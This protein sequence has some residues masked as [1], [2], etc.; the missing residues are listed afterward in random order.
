MVTSVFECECIIF[1]FIIYNYKM[2][3][4]N[5]CLFLAMLKFKI[6]HIVT[7]L[8]VKNIFGELLLQFTFSV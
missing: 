4:G 2:W 3:L 1:I 7:S 8:S 6:V 5:F